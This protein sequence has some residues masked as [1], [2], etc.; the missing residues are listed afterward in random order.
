[1]DNLWIFSFLVPGIIAMP[2]VDMA[3]V[4][5]SPWWMDADRAPRPSPGWSPAASCTW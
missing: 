4:L 2:G 5:S 3:F 1:M